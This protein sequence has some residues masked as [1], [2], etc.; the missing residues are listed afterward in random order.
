MANLDTLLSP[1]R[2]GGRKFRNRLVCSPISVNLAGIDGSVTDDLVKFY[3]SMGNTGVGMVT[4]GATAVSEAG[5]GTANGMHI[6]PPKLNAGLVRLSE[7]VK[8]TGAKVSL[9][10]FHVGAQGNT[11][12]T[13]Q[14]VV[15]PS[16]YVCPDI[17]IE[18]RELKI[19][20]IQR[21]ED[22]FADAVLV[23]LECGFDFVEF[24]IAHGY[25]L[26]NFVAPFFNKRSDEYGG[27]EEN[28]LRIIKNII[29]KVRA[30]DRDALKSVG[31]RISGHD[32]VDDGLTIE[33]GQNLVR[34]LEVHDL[35]YWVVSAGIYETA[36]QKYV[37]MKKGSYYQ[38]AKQL[39]GVAKSPVVAQGGIWNLHQ[40]AEIVATGQG[41]MAGM[42]RA[43]I[44]DPDIIK[45]TEYGQEKKIIPCLECNRCRYIKR[46]DLTFDCVRPE[47]Y[48]PDD[49]R[50]RLL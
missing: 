44:A 30:R 20:E 6:G 13:N 7:A 10:I 49:S 22:E 5:G 32:F 35:A 15:G 11:N 45:K 31:A 48:H 41:D 2:V 29:S 47:G 37:H 19:S 50:W 12:Y 28:R 9:Q 25:L 27:A 34:M 18:A 4:I 33:R 16:P 42:A 21:I 43:L 39:K 46:K 40:A 26:H 24:H 23:G 36:D 3:G 1:Y 8:E 38:Y 17:G 14:P